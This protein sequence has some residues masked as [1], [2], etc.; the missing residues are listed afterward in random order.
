MKND[1]CLLVAPFF[2]PSYIPLA[3]P[4]LLASLK[5]SG[6][7]ATSLDLNIEFWN[8]YVVKED[9]IKGINLLKEYLSKILLYKK[10]LKEI[11]NDSY[12][13]HL[14]KLIIKN[15]F[16]N[17]KELADFVVDDTYLSNLIYPFLYSQKLDCD[18]IGISVSYEDQFVIS[19]I[20][21]KILK[22][23]GKKII[24]GGSYISA[25][26]SNVL[27]DILDAIPVCDCFIKYPG[28][29]TLP[30]ICKKYLNDDY[31]LECVPNIIWKSKK[32]SIINQE[33]H[34]QYNLVNIIPDYS[35][36]NLDSY[37][38]PF[39]F[40]S[41]LLTQGCYYRKCTFCTNY[42][43][44]GNCYNE[45]C[46]DTLAKELEIIS[47]MGIKYIYFVDDAIKPA[48]LFELLSILERY[49]FKWI[50]ETRLDKIFYSDEFCRK[51]YSS[52]CR[53][54][55]FGIETN[56]KTTLKKI[57]KGIDNS[58]LPAISKILNNNKIMVSSTF[59]VNFPWENEQDVKETLDYICVQ[60][61]LNFFGLSNFAL[62][63]D[64]IIYNEIIKENKYHIKKKNV[65]S[66]IYRIEGFREN[67]A[68]LK[69]FEN[70]NYVSTHKKISSL[71]IHRM[72]FIMIE[73]I[74]ILNMQNM[75]KEV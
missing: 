72:H 48:L 52:G 56:S 51:L 70:I 10:R 63:R 59:I 14:K 40:C 46:V 41:V 69:E 75:K 11:S 27:K 42:M 34:K 61:N 6:I 49:N 12:I 38:S 44:Y 35:K 37:L 67:T 5:N 71:I 18:I 60:K 23:K 21:A 68:S 65:I 53:L 26:E 19:L 73:D 62:L 50:L 7:K 4:T 29:Y 31:S 24:F 45:K 20:I 33:D 13:F 28:D 74:G 17:V 47:N 1:V 54:L 2:V 9:K 22:S 55:S 8:K 64:S 25:I 15:D 16:K 3:I 39:P 66:N 43:S 30:V 32:H 36:I 58:L 57:N